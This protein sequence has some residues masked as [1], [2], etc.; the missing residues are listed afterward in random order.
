MTKDEKALPRI[1]EEQIRISPNDYY[2]VI[3]ALFLVIVPLCFVSNH[4]YHKVL[5]LQEN[6][7]YQ[8]SR[9]QL[10][11]TNIP[12]PLGKD[13]K[14]RTMMELGIATGTDKIYHHGYHRFYPIFLEALR[15]K[16]ISMVEIGYL[17]GDSHRMWNSYFPKGRV[18]FIEKDGD[19]QIENGFG[20]DQSSKDDLRK[21]L[22]SKNMTKSL[23]I[24]VDDGSHHPSHQLFSFKYLYKWGLKPGGIYI[25]EDI[26]MSYW[27]R[28]DTYGF[29]LNYGRDRFL[30]LIIDLHSLQL[31]AV[32]S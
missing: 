22:A 32:P 1:E 10:A 31:V 6:I 15:D 23:D 4:F 21:F 12:E 9:R 30:I 19:H 27:I 14:L 13:G 3:F 20:G 7:A 24:I 8:E 2:F 5:D 28:G 26:E 11:A 17:N 16:P 29:K 25:I 18:Y